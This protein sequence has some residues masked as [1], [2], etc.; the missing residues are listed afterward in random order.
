MSWTHRPGLAM[1]AALALTL[2]TSS[3][4]DEA[5]PSPQERCKTDGLA[6]FGAGRLIVDQGKPGPLELRMSKASG[7]LQGRS[8]TLRFGAAS[9]PEGSRELLLRVQATDSAEELIE[10]LSRATADGPATF[11][12]VDT[13]QVKAG[14]QSISALD[15]YDCDMSKGALCAQLAVDRQVDGLISD[16]DEVVFNAR[17]GQLVFERIDGLSSTFRMSF[18]LQLSGNL[19]DRDDMNASNTWSG[20]VDS[21]YIGTGGGRWELR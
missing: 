20:C 7:F 15:G 16:E 5:A 4:A 8:M 17:D 12:V 19:F 14:G 11:R 18:S 10:R 1:S 2:L 21:G 3:C 6:A 9:L 13:S